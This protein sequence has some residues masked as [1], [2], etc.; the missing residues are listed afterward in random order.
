MSDIMKLKNAT[1][2]GVM[3][4]KNALA[5]CGGN[6]E[7]AAALLRE[8]GIAKAAKKEGSDRV[9][10]EGSVFTYNHMGGKIAVLVEINCET[11]FAAKADAFLELGKNIAM[12]IAAAK[13][14]YLEESEVPTAELET[15]KEILK[16]QALNEGKPAN[17]V[18]KM[19]E[20]RVKKYY[21]EICLVHQPFV[22]DPSKSIKDVVT[23][24][25]AFIGEKITIRRFVRF[26]MG[27][28]LEK[29]EDNFAEEVA[30]QMNK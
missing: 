17:V 24:A 5:E 22:K 26:E 7:K 23:E 10:S 9:N 16:K 18:D 19:V 21:Q 2:A 15:E 12:H 20:G 3:D 27:E 8:R 13:P 25:I 29:K 14:L 11:D 1:G 30:K 28:G 4:C 6:Y